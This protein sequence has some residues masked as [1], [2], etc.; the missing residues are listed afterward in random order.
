MMSTVPCS[1]T[2]KTMWYGFLTLQWR[3]M[4]VM[5]SQVMVNSTTLS[6]GCWGPTKKTS[7]LSITGLEGV[8]RRLG[9]CVATLSCSC[10]LH[11]ILILNEDIHEVTAYGWWCFTIAFNNTNIATWQEYITLQWRHLSLICLKS[12]VTWLLFQQLIEANNK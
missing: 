9:W 12:S 5:V 1:N 10:L 6:T 2:N 8:H 4:S 3:H 7:Q 11:K